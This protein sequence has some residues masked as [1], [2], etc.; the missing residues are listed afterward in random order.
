M[1]LI[2]SYG[3]KLIEAERERQIT[4]EGYTAEHDQGHA[5][6]ELALAAACY[7]VNEPI[8]VKRDSAHGVSFRDPWPWDDHFD[9]RKSDGA[10]FVNRLPL[11]RQER[12][13]MLVKAGAL[14]AAEIDSL[15]K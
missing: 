11:K 7:A 9:R 15:G 2:R 12:L 4:K 3:V 5:D 6:G 14:I 13:R 1:T 8:Y 10:N